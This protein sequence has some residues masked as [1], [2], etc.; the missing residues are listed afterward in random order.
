[1][2][3]G[4]S[5]S[6]VGFV[7]AGLAQ[8]TVVVDTIW[9]WKSEDLTIKTP[10]ASDLNQH[11]CQTISE[12]STSFWFQA[13]IPVAARCFARQK[14]IDAPTKNLPN[15]VPCSIAQISFFF[16]HNREYESLLLC[17]ANTEQTVPRHNV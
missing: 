17:V 7:D 15:V 11:T 3:G 8:P 2:V 1:M 10:V 5:V 13:V 4:I 9:P 14:R 16:F 6:Q 12:S